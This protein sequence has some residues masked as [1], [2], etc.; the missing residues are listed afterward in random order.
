MLRYITRLSLLMFI[1]GST[2]QTIH[3]IH[4]SR[5]R[6][7]DQLLGIEWSGRRHS[8][9]V[10][11]LM[12]TGPVT[13][14]FLFLVSRLMDSLSIKVSRDKVLDIA[15]GSQHRRGTEHKANEGQVLESE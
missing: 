2:Q 9:V 11:L 12:L 8:P 6:L 14:F 3:C 13:Q 15:S 5:G 4:F 7:R 1:F 10:L